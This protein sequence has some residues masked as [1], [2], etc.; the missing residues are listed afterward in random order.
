MD[1]AAIEEYG[2]RGNEF[3]DCPPDIWQSEDF[4]QIKAWFSAKKRNKYKNTKN[5]NRDI[6]II[7]VGNSN[8]GKTALRKF[9]QS[10]IFDKNRISTI[11]MEIS[12]WLPNCVVETPEEIT[13]SN[14]FED[15][16]E[17]V[18]INFWD[19]GGQ[20]YYHG[21]YRL[22]LSNYAIYILLW[23]KESNYYGTIPTW[24]DEHKKEEI[25]HFHYTYWL[26]NIRYFA[27]DSPI[28]MVQNKI[29]MPKNGKE[30]ISN[31]LMKKYNVSEDH[32]LSLAKASRG[33]TRFK[34]SFDV[35]CDDLVEQIKKREQATKIGSWMKIKNYILELRCDTVAQDNPFSAYKNQHYISTEKFNEVVITIDEEL[36]LA[37][38]RNELYTLPRWL[39]NIGIII[40]FGKNES[41]NDN[42]YLDPLALTES[43][44]S[45]LNESVRKK[46]GRFSIEDLPNS[47][48]A[49][50]TLESIDLMKE[51][52]I[53]FEQ[54]NGSKNAKV[55]YVAPQYLPDIHEHQELFKLATSSFKNRAIFVRLPIFYYL[56]VLQR[57]I[58]FYGR[59]ESVHTRYFW[60][61]GI[62][63]SKG[64]EDAQ[65]R[66][67]VKGFLESSN[68]NKPDENRGIIYIGL[69]DDVK[70]EQNCQGEVFKVILA[71]LENRDMRIQENDS[72]EN[73][74]EIL[75]EGNPS[76]RKT[77]FRRSMNWIEEFLNMDKKDIPHW[78]KIVE[79][80]HDGQNFCSYLKI[81][82]ANQA[83]KVFA[84]IKST[85]VPVKNFESILD[86][87]CKRPLKLFLSYSHKDTILMKRF[88]THLA[89]LK[90]QEIIETWTDEAIMPG[91]DWN[92]VIKS[93]LA[94]ADLVILLIS[95]DFIASSYIWEEELKYAIE[96]R[97]L[98]KK[99]IIPVYLRPFEYNE[100]PFLKELQ[101]IPNGIIDDKTG[102]KAI[103]RWEN[104]DIA[105][106]TVVAAIKK[107][108]EWMN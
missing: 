28:L 22:F 74:K 95:A 12:R 1:L 46:E 45:I 7:F 60:K 90:R 4:K 64:T 104:E 103:S 50:G 98:G 10:G 70:D 73:N 37:E 16:K 39:H 26:D 89:P 68:P 30:R 24:I 31:K 87:K 85:D 101:L 58:Y 102:L 88:D 79:V 17:N 91:D 80:S 41:L 18:A 69:E 62:L 25:R 38:N 49:N 48:L 59:D 20:E 77:F 84:N 33:E 36:A 83:G 40:F 61:H 53:I 54:N 6:K 82:K 105:F 47:K 92:E 97:I 71:I 107:K 75:H 78:L 55:T 57:L 66:V 13:C 11:G 106:R 32:Y 27:A 21:T 52:E 9:I 81:C 44:Y 100:V 65:I 63:L 2:L 86:R 96:Q 34:R 14:A 94:E 72:L 8:V 67:L 108:I 23:E 19:F 99:V 35:F 56:K 29:D 3:N 42:L 43:I 93:N 15:I 5:H 76:R 51:M